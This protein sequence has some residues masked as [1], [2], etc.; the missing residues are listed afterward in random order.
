MISLSESILKSVSAGKE[1]VRKRIEDWIAENNYGK[2]V[3]ND[4]FTI[5][6]FDPSS[7]GNVIKGNIPDYIVIDSAGFITITDCTSLKN[8]PKDMRGLI[9]LNS[10]FED[11]SELKSDDCDLLV[12]NC[13][14]NSIKGIPKDAEFIAL[15][16]N[17]KHFKKK[18]IKK[19][20]NTKPQNIHTLGW[21]DNSGRYYGTWVLGPNDVDYCEKEVELLEQKYKKAI[22]DLDHTVF[23]CNSRDTS[24]GIRLD[25]LPKSEHPNGI[26]DNSIFLEFRY[27]VE[28]STIEVSNYGHLELTPQDK[29]GKYKYYALKGF[30]A[31]YYDAGGKRFRKTRLDNFDADNVY[32]KTIDW[33]KAVVD[34]ALK[35]Q[36]GTLKRK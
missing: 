2:Y 18:D 8:L 19:L 21:H 36:G 1:E 4:D 20:V 24:I 9:I 3:V 31:P 28:D 33:I 34:A 7:K 14:F 25:F 26:S 5:T 17:T 13:D 29:A 16:N 32:D 10:K 23:S 6:L 15:G 27:D 35:D 11:F 30:T 12:S 22:P